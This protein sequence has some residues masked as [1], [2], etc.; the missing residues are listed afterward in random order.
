MKES[1]IDMCAKNCVKVHVC[2]YGGV[3]VIVLVSV[4]AQA[5]GGE[6]KAAF[7]APALF[8]PPPRAPRAARQWVQRHNIYIFEV[9]VLYRM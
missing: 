1:T 9:R 7:P 2:G 4:R 5:R 3:G 6:G 8:L